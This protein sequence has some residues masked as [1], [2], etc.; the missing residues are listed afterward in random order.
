M[1][2]LSQWMFIQQVSRFSEQIQSHIS[3]CL[4]RVICMG[5]YS[6]HTAL[7][8]FLDLDI[9]V[10]P[11]FAVYPVNVAGD[12]GIHP[13]LALLATAIAPADHTH[14]SHLAILWTDKRTA[15]V[16]LS[17]ISERERHG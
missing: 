2:P 6:S 16:A 9:M 11:P 12:S 3:L 7:P 13:R 8:Q 1:H 15:R 5:V 4:F 10:C 14:Q 17:T